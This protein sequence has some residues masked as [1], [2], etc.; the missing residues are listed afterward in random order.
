MNTLVRRAQSMDCNGFW[1]Q[2]ILAAEVLDC[3][4]IKCAEGALRGPRRGQETPLR[5]LHVTR[6]QLLY[7]KG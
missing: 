5:G 4:G 2:E 3:I 6:N 1:I 7:L